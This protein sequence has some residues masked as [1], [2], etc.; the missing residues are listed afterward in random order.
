ML[1]KYTYIFWINS[2]YKKGK[3]G[4][5]SVPLTNTNNQSGQQTN[6]WRKY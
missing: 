3:S 1:P 6:V 4:Y 2:V 5:S